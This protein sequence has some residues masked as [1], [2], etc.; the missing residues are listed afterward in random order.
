MSFN[1]DAKAHVEN[2]WYG[3]WIVL[4]VCPY[5]AELV[6]DS[7]CRFYVNVDFFTIYIGVDTFLKYASF[8]NLITPG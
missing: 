4:V 2:S 1:L 3:L 7:F 8:D 5:D 6:H